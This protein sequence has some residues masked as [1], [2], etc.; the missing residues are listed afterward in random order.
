MKAIRS[1]CAWALLYATGAFAV[2]TEVS[3]AGRLDRAKREVQQTEKE[4]AALPAGHGLEPRL[5]NERE[6]IRSREKLIRELIAK[7]APADE[8][9]ARLGELEM[10]AH[11]FAY[12]PLRARI[13]AA[14]KARN[15][16]EPRWGVVPASDVERVAENTVPSYREA[17][18]ELHGVEGESLSAQLIAVPFDGGLQFT[19]G[20]DRTKGDIRFTDLKSEAG[21]IIEA[22]QWTLM[23]VDE[24]R[25]LEDW[26]RGN[27]L[28]Y[29]MPP[30]MLRAGRPE[31]LFAQHPY[32][33]KT[34]FVGKIAVF[35]C[36][37][38]VPA[39]QTPG[40]YQGRIQVWPLN[41]ENPRDVPV[42]L[43]IWKFGLPA[44]WPLDIEAGFKTE[45]VAKYYGATGEGKSSGGDFASAFK[46]SH[47]QFLKYY[48]ITGLPDQEAKTKD[49]WFLA[50][51]PGPLSLG[52]SPITVRLLPW[53]V[54]ASG[55]P[56]IVIPWLHT[57]EGRHLNAD[58]YWGQG[59]S[60]SWPL[61]PD[62]K[63]G[64]LVY[65]TKPA[66]K[67]FAPSLRLE[68]L[69]DGLQDVRYLAALATAERAAPDG[70]WKKKANALLQA[71]R[72]LGMK[73][74]ASNAQADLYRIRLEA[75]Q[76]L[77]T[78]PLSPSSNA[79][80]GG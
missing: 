52:A 14:A 61:Q 8:I 63:I 56:G 31:V 76:L 72:N 53:R 15:Q 78:A 77:E 41:F 33:G 46:G 21:A 49:R 71:A 50:G 65:P 40:V 7:R 11:D 25:R 75:G 64:D 16:P 38:D 20:W 35:R 59:L 74:E 48:G 18:I 69:R 10:A 9:E 4:A 22:K 12:L 32:L 34:V 19:F 70:E 60:T 24:L 2:E 42:Q 67:G 68:V 44:R 1:V 36:R 47:D 3:F 45:N 80:G 39:K 23:R 28:D 29:Y 43:V 13:V 30:E 51:E 73:P 55:Q 6:T 26:P 17:R 66:F 37:L 62:D 27:P 57:W 58:P 54:W 5:R 79:G